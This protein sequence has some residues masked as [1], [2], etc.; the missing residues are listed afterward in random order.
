MKPSASNLSKSNLLLI[1]C[2]GILVG[3]GAAVVGYRIGRSMAL[4][5]KAR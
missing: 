3:L 2:L 4:A 1:V 5:E